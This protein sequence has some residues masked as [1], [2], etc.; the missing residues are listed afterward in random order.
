M[1]RVLLI[2]R[3]RLGDIVACL[4]AARL[5]ANAGNEVDFLCFPKYH[6][7]FKAVSYCHPVDMDA[8]AKKNTYD[9]VYDLEITRAEYDSY[10]ASRIK[11]RDYSY[12]KYPDL[13][14]ARSERP[15]FDRL[16]DISAYSLPADYA[17]AAPFGVSQVTKISPTWFRAQC[18]AISPGPWYTLTDKPARR[19]GLGQPLVAKSLD[20][21]PS[22]IAQASNFV[23]INSAPN[24]IA[25]G[26]R[27]SWHLV[28]EPG[29]GGQD[30]YN[31]PGQIVLHQPRDL[32]RHS[33]RFW[34]HYWR[35]RLMGIPAGHDLGR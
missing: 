2:Y 7:I 9:R 31:A 23:T 13:E 11:W 27:S 5:L 34:V 33:W 16:P 32:E 25:S 4:P 18:E 20:H 12:T 19:S 15:H 28:H 21:L 8:L 1:S 10:R 26:I 17:L 14:P 24:I 35:R 6:G 3:Q 30:N 29:F 22:L